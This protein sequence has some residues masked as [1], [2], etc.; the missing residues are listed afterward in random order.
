MHGLASTVGSLNAI[1]SE[2]VTYKNRLR[3]AEGSIL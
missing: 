2:I 1:S 3:I